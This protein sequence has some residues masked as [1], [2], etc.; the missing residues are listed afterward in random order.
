MKDGQRRVIFPKQNNGTFMAAV[1]RCEKRRPPEFSYDNN[2]R[3]DVYETRWRIFI[4]HKAF[5]PKKK[6]V[7]IWSRLVC[8]KKLHYVGLQEKKSI[9]VTTDCGLYRYCLWKCPSL[10][11]STSRN[12]RIYILYIHYI[13]V[14][15]Y[16]YVW[17]K[18]FKPVSFTSRPT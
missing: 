1:Q 7:K 17:R 13:R 4:G 3:N 10:H 14:F 18:L 5:F 6:K 9:Y 15:M 8:K 11:N 2:T 16:A 12:V